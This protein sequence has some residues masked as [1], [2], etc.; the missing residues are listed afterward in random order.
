[1]ASEVRHGTSRGAASHGVLREPLCPACAMYAA[2]KSRAHR[3][4][5]G[6]GTAVQVSALALGRIL[7]GWPPERALAADGVGPLTIDMLRNYRAGEQH[8]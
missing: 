8:G 6:R 7:R 5:S 1:M 3:I 4:I 2:D